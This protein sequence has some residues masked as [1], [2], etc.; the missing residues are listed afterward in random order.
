[1]EENVKS[2]KKVFFDESETES[3]EGLPPTQLEQR[4]ILTSS[5]SKL[6]TD[7][8][9]VDIDDY[10]FAS[11]DDYFADGVDIYKLLF[12]PTWNKFFS[13]AYLLI[14]KIE[15]DLT[16]YLKSSK[17]IVP[18]PELVFNIF[19]IINLSMIKVVILGQDPYQ[20]DTWA[21]GCSFSVPLGVK[22][23]VSLN[24]IYNNLIKFNHIKTKPRGG[25]L[26]G[27]VLQGCF[28]L[29]ASL[30]TFVDDSNSHKKTWLEFTKQLMTYINLNCDR[31]VFLAWGADAFRMCEKIDR[32]KH[33]VI[34]SSHPSGR[35]FQ[36]TFTGM[37]DGITK[38]YPSFESVDHFGL[39]NKY[40]I[41][42][43]KREIIWD[44]IY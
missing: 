20:N 5:K 11:W 30:T 31:I 44:L 19:N 21:T 2:G 22:P 26:G 29:N 16:K 12:N 42:N 24:N 33:L 23:P 6:M 39:A 27:W 40:L 37:L 1:M 34:A 28:M 38:V 9:F 7:Y 10:V 4:I 8:Q 36:K 17:K 18:P 15:T 32:T 35:S 43:S 13:E 3:E 41:K 25:C 14:T